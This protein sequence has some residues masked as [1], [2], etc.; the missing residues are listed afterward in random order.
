M[1]AA[2]ERPPRRHPQVSDPRGGRLR[3]G[4]M[5]ATPPEHGPVDVPQPHARGVTCVP[6]VPSTTRPASSSRPIAARPPLRE[7]ACASVLGRMDPGGRSR[8]RAAVTSSR[9]SRRF[10]RS[11]P[12]GVAGIDARRQC[13]DVGARAGSTSAAERSLSATASTPSTR[14]FRT[15]TG[16]PPGGR[17]RVLRHRCGEVRGRRVPSAGEALRGMRHPGV[18]RS[19]GIVVRGGGWRARRSVREY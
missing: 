1:P 13:E 7:P 3:T 19:S 4:G 14:R 11:A 6:T 16:T 2:S 17:F 18:M 12:V 9:E 5:T 8:A 10:G 15:A